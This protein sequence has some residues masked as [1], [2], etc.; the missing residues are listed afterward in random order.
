MSKADGVGSASERAHVQRAPRS[1][2]SPPAPVSTPP[3]LL[4]RP[5][6]SW[7]FF[8]STHRGTARS[9][10]NERLDQLLLQPRLP[11]PATCL[12]GR[13]STSC[14]AA[15]STPPLLPRVFKGDGRRVAQLL[16]L[17]LLSCTCLQGRWSTSC[18]VRL[19][20][21]G[22]ENHS[23]TNVLGHTMLKSASS[24]RGWDRSAD[25]RERLKSPV[26]GDARRPGRGVRKRAG[27]HA[28]M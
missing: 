10:S 12:Q 23:W 28:R 20:A 8:W 1:T 16:P 27:P 2:P 19:G 25:A 14:P 9:T 13:W 4:H 17:L 11:S 15:A 18:E 5:H 21:R 24:I 22:R 7:Q 6:V 3:L 26:D